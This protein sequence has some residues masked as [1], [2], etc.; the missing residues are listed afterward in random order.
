LREQA[1]IPNPA[2][3]CLRRKRNRYKPVPDYLLGAQKLALAIDCEIPFA[4]EGC[5]V[6][7][8]KLPAGVGLIAVDESALKKNF[9]GSSTG[10]AVPLN[11]FL[12]NKYSV[13]VASLQREDGAD[14]AFNLL[15]SYL[16]IALSGRS[17]GSLF[18]AAG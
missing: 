7:A 2:G 4:I 3:L 16:D 9:D 8:L 11:Q 10:S 18:F 12:R 15:V 6:I 1:C 5:P 13:L 14:L 17:G